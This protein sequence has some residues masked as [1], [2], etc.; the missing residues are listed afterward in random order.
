MGQTI[1]NE[2]K[3]EFDIEL[4]ETLKTYCD[5]IQLTNEM[6]IVGEFE[7]TIDTFRKK[8]NSKA[9]K[10]YYQNRNLYWCMKDRGTKFLIY[11]CLFKILKT[12]SWDNIKTE[13]KVNYLID[14]NKIVDIDESNFKDDEIIILEYPK[15]FERVYEHIISKQHKF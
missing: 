14:W 15:M 5:A 12:T 6:T 8:M 7:N 11:E 3:D 4:H 13:N 2:L 9:N 10:L 1:F